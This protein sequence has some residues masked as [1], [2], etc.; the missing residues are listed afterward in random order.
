M[1]STASRWGIA[2]SAGDA[3]DMWLRGESVRRIGDGEEENDVD[4]VRSE[5]GELRRGAN[6]AGDSVWSGWEPEG[7]AD[8]REYEVERLIL[9]EEEGTST[10]TECLC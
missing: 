2:S 3:I 1:S 7:K 6:E 4:A 9:V 8:D 5:T 10:D